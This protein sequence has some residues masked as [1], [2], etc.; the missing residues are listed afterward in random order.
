MNPDA[1]PHDEPSFID[2]VEP[3]AVPAP[4]EAVREAQASGDSAQVAQAEAVADAKYVVQPINEHK[5]PESASGLEN[6]GVSEKF[7]TDIADKILQCKESKDKGV[8][9]TEIASGLFLRMH[10]LN[11]ALATPFQE[12]VGL[13]RESDTREQFQSKSATLKEQMISE[14]EKVKELLLS[15]SQLDIFP[16]KKELVDLLCAELGGTYLTKGYPDVTQDNH[17]RFGKIVD[18]I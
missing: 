2:L 3:K 12:E 16:N 11:T 15:N 7:A 17:I 14:V 5:A 1:Q 18:L 9:P 4:M 6:L 13:Y 8:L 10:D